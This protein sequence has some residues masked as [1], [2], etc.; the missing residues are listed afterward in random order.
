MLVS[1]GG[2]GQL[3]DENPGHSAL[4]V[5][6]EI[7]RYLRPWDASLL[8]ATSKQSSISAFGQFILHYAL[9]ILC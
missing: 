6:V 7:F 5:P 3:E 9:G 4:E 8:Q 1:E 2:S